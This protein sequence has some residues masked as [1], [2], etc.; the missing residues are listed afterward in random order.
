MKLGAN[1]KA[2]LTQIRTEPGQWTAK[3]LADDFGVQASSVRRSLREMEKAGLIKPGP[4]PKRIG[5][6]GGAP[7][8]AWFPVEE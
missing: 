2:F 7:P 8:R 5:S 4:R 6:H 1:Q 3:A